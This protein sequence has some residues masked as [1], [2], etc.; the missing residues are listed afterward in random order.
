MMKLFL[1]AA[2]YFRRSRR[3]FRAASAHLDE[4]EHWRRDPLSHPAIA[5]MSQRDLADLPLRPTNL[6]SC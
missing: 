6:G 5:A 2:A 1:S 3:E 4:Q